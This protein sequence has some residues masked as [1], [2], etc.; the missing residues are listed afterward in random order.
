MYLDPCL[1]LPQCLQLAH[2]NQAFIITK[3]APSIVHRACGLPVDEGRRSHLTSI[4]KPQPSSRKNGLPAP[5]GS[6]CR[7][8]VQPDIPLPR[9]LASLG[10]SALR[11]RF[12]TTF[13][14]DRLHR[15]QAKQREG[16][17]GHY[18]NIQGEQFHTSAGHN[19]PLVMSKWQS[20]WTHLASR[21]T[22]KQGNFTKTLVRKVLTSA[23]QALF[24]FR[25][26]LC[27]VWG[28]T[29]RGSATPHRTIQQRISHKYLVRP[30]WNG[31]RKQGA[32][33]GSG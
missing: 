10:R 20:T 11:Q 1:P 12:L 29:Q 15:L 16:C 21:L 17:R 32:D 6:T 5:P 4:S 22:R 26:K 24:I 25:H 2:R 31:R 14:T 8:V 9:P 3:L 19:L 33:D 7:S 28:V 27:S 18:A 23:Q 13:R 30:S